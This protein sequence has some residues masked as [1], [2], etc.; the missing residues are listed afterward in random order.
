MSI[1][2]CPIPCSDVFFF[3][4]FLF[5][6]S[7]KTLWRVIG[8]LSVPKLQLHETGFL[9]FLSYFSF[10]N[11]FFYRSLYYQRLKEM[12]GVPVSVSLSRPYLLLIDRY[13]E[14][15]AMMNRPLSC[16]SLTMSLLSCNIAV[17]RPEYSVSQL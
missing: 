7:L 13:S 3:F 1:I 10:F 5:V 12:I 14:G 2:Q 4:F 17:Q 9:L 6:V 15:I 16:P 8:N 11:H